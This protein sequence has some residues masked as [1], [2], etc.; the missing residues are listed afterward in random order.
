[1]T[2]STT[3][4]G[5][6]A[7]ADPT[8]SVLDHSRISR[9]VAG[10]RPHPGRTTIA[11]MAIAI[12]N[13][14]TRGKEMLAPLAPPKLRLFVCGPTV[15]DLAHLGHAKTYV[16][17]D[18]IA[19]HL[20]HRGYDLSYVQNITDIDDKI[21]NR[22]NELGIQADQLARVQEEMFIA[23]MR[24][25]GVTSVDRY[26]R[27]SDF[28]PEIVSQ[29]ERLLAN[30]NAYELPDG[31]YFDI[32]TF[33]D[34]GKL[35]R[36][37]NL[38]PEDAVS[39]IDENVLKRHPGDFALWKRR[40]PNEPYWE[41]P[42]GAGRPGWHIEDTAITETLF[43]AQYDIH[44]GAVDLIFPHHEAEIAQMESI[45]GRAPLA[46][47]WVHTGFLTLRDAK[48]SKSTG[49]SLTIR[50]ILRTVDPRVLRFF[51]LSHH[52]RS[53]VEYDDELLVSAR[54]ALARIDNFY[55]RLPEEPPGT[56]S[57]EAEDARAAMMSALDDDF[58]TPR[59]LSAL[60]AFIREQHRRPR[61]APGSRLLLQEFN[62]IFRVLPDSAEEHQDDGWVQREVDRRQELRG[63]RRFGEA[64]EIRDRLHAMNVIIEDTADGVRWHRQTMSA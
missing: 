4:G 23:D 47:Y 53:P 63:Q 32:A 6:S 14:L 30:G 8:R 57:H 24:V 17:F 18:A 39:R 10:E 2:F 40:K 58:D 12:W 25:L 42:L 3:N 41:T 56:T 33:T 22:A 26:A 16:Q 13:T 7:T 64:D 54:A 20:R 35:A 29:I 55:L 44:G 28:I 43:G 11:G 15:Y 27:A 37:Q 49:N 21:I 61:P 9:D 45:S 46:R 52:Y 38:A 48:M 5:A 19:R 59:A 50:H 1:M 60:F 51:F 31:F 36:R 62:D 34:Y